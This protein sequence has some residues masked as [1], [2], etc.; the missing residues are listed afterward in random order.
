MNDR[1]NHLFDETVQIDYLED[2]ADNPPEN[3]YT[4]FRTELD[5]ILEDLI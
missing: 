4:M 2:E 3:R 5:C 1:Y